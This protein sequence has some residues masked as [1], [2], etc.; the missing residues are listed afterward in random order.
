MGS[1]GED[2]VGGEGIPG[3]SIVL[4]E[5]LTGYRQVGWG[6][7]E[8]PRP[9]DGGR[10]LEEDSRGP[11]VDYLRFGG[12]LGLVGEEGEK[13]VFG[14]IIIRSFQQVPFFFRFAGS[15]KCLVWVGDFGE[16]LQSSGGGDLFPGAGG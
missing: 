7:G 9:V 5:Q 12:S 15:G 2:G 6:F 3:H 4:F 16:P 10:G 13:E 14:V 8:F 1:G 11:G